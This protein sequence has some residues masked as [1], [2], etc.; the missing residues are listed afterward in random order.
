MRVRPVRGGPRDFEGPL[1]P[2]AQGKLFRILRRP[3]A[4]RA[5]LLKPLA[6]GVGRD[7]EGGEDGGEGWIRALEEGQKEVLGADVVV[8]KADGLGPGGGEKVAQ[9][10]LAS[11]ISMMGMPSSTG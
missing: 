11:S 4:L 9:S 8:L 10:G 7:G 6:E 1:R 5:P 2:G 3:L